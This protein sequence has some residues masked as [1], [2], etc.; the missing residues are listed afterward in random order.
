MKSMWRKTSQKSDHFT[1]N[2]SQNQQTKNTQ[3]TSEPTAQTAT[4]AEDTPL[5]ANVATELKGIQAILENLAKDMT[6]LK[7]NLWMKL[8]TNLGAELPRPNQ[9]FPG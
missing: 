2:P 9:E 6:G 7:N 5:K 4:H 3:D 1:H 8:L